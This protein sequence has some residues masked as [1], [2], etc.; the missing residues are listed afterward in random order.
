MQLTPYWWDAAPRPTHENKSVPGKTDVVIVGAGFTGLTAAISL[1][2]AGLSVTVI[3]RLSPGEGASSRNGG[4]CS[5]NLKFS[6][7]ELIKRNGLDRAKALFQEGVDARHALAQLI[8]D[9]KIDCDFSHTGR[10]TGANRI[11]DYNSLG[12]EADLMNKHLNLGIEMVPKS[13]QHNHLK[14]DFYNGG[15]A[16]D[17]IFGLHPGKFVNGLF[18]RAIQAGANVVYP[19]DVRAVKSMAKGFTVTTDVG[20]IKTDHVLIA[21]NGY[22]TKSTP[23]FNRRIIPIPSQIVATEVLS[24]DVIQEL[25]PA[26]NM[27]SDTRNLYNYYRPSPDG[28]RIIFGGRRGADTDDPKQKA[29]HL[30]R[31]LIEIFPQLSPIN[32]THS[33]HGYTGYSFDM[34]PHLSTH[35]GVHFAGAYCGSGVVWAPWVGKMA[36][37]RILKQ[38][39]AQ[40]D[41]QEKSCFETSSFPTRPLYFGKPWFLPLVIKWYGF[42]DLF[43]KGRHSG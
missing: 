9:E 33:W 41:E 29:D 4:I 38:S 11:A 7:S 3:D 27:Y 36:A 30:K 39:G 5:G 43:G 28:T 19:V 20:D 21:T 37:R 31:N 8:T 14:T 42:K 22:T 2:R 26:G 34:L 23:W 18:D 24:K 12:I 10:F 35:N 25:M 17:D 1:V 6:F 32:L 16:R 15:Q 40:V 13:Q